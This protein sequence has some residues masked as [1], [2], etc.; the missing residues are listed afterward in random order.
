[1]NLFMSLSGLIYV[2]FFLLY[3]GKSIINDISSKPKETNEYWSKFKD[4]GIYNT[5]IGQIVKKQMGAIENA[6]I[7]IN[8]KTYPIL[9]LEILPKGNQ[10]VWII[11]II[12]PNHYLALGAKMID[13]EKA[14]PFNFRCVYLTSNIEG[15]IR[16][17]IKAEG[18]LHTQLLR[19]TLRLKIKGILKS[20]SNEPVNVSIISE[21]YS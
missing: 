11:N 4:K 16:E 5:A 3:A 10:V 20:K 13:L 1:M 12:D 18:K 19:G 6:I 8:D 21:E 15:N 7:S 14:A 2:I 9:G 17:K